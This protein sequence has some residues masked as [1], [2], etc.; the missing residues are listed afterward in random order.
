MCF[1]VLACY[2]LESLALTFRMNCYFGTS[3]ES[4]RMQVP[5]GS[6][7][8]W[9]CRAHCGCEESGAGLVEGCIST[10]GDHSTSHLPRSPHTSFLWLL[11]RSEETGRALWA[12]PCTSW[13]EQGATSAASSPALWPHPAL[14]HLCFLFPSSCICLPCPVPPQEQPLCQGRG[15]SFSV[16]AVP[17]Q[18]A[19]LFHKWLLL[20]VHLYF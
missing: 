17:L 1:S 9:C 7:R 5:V 16:H 6:S 13:A 14:E 2:L 20:Y 3:F 15:Q 19:H 18:G 10:Q 11:M 8:W 4:P 12:G